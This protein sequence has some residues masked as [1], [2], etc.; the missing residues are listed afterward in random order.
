MSSSAEVYVLYTVAELAKRFGLRASEA[1]ADIVFVDSDK[2][3]LGQG[4]YGLRF[5]SVPIGQEKGERFEQFE[6]HLGVQDGMV[7]VRH[8]IELED[9]VETAL[10][11][12]PRARFR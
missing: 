12:A 7:K 9:L 2:D 8:I 6:A 10:A 3:P 5:D 1:D 11:T 4:Y